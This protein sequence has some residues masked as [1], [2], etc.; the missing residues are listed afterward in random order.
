MTWFH[1]HTGN[2]VNS[3]TAAKWRNSTVKSGTLV[4][5][6]AASS[7]ALLG[8][9]G[10]FGDQALFSLAE[11]RRAISSKRVKPKH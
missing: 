11:V 8:L 9:A 6:I 5:I 7:A 1:L 3:R 2:S 4:V 10:W